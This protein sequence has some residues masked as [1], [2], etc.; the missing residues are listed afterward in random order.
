MKP[1]FEGRLDFAPDVP[2]ERGE[3][4]LEGGAVGYVLDRKAAVVSYALRRHRVTLLAFPAAGLDWPG[5]G[6]PPV[7]LSRRGF[8]VVAWR[9]G[10]LVYA[11]VS[12]VN[13]AELEEL[14]AELARDT[15]G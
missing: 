13:E 9:A 6:A 7:A 10:E 15:G 4:R 11:L 3:L 8:H 5:A 1:W 2:G 14:G 12:D